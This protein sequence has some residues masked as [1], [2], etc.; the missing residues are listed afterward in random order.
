MFISLYTVRVILN[1]L[2]IVDYG[3]Y[4]V[5]AGIVTMF[6]FLSGAMATASQRFFSFEMGRGDHDKLQKTFCM[7]MSIYMLIALVVLVLAESVGLWFVIA[8]LVIPKNRMHAAL[9]VYQFSIMSFL[10]T[11]ITTPYIAVIIARENMDVYA[12][13]SILESL[14]KLAVVFFLRISRFDSLV[15][16]GILIFFV[17]LIVS[18]LFI[19]TCRK[20]YPESRFYFY[21]DT[22]M[23]K[24]LFS[25]TGW[26]LFGASSGIAKN[27]AINIL[28]NL[29]FGP[30]VNAARGIAT[31]VSGAVAS[32]SQNFSIAV[33]P[34]IIKK[35]AAGEKEEM[36]KLVFLS[37]KLTSFLMY[38]FVLPLYLEMPM[39]MLLWLGQIPAHVVAFTRLIL[40][41][42]LI[43]SI[44]Y[45][46]MTASQATGKI[47]LYQ[48]TIGSINLLNLPVSWIALQLG[49]VPEIVFVIMVIITVI[50]FIVRLLI[51]K[52]LCVFSIKNYWKS[53][54][55]PVSLVSIFGAIGPIF[56]SSRFSFGIAR[57]FATLIVSTLTISV[58]ILFLGLNRNERHGLLAK[59]HFIIRRDH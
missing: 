40:I 13:V 41:D 43:D 19:F 52:R 10:A 38:V 33:R 18:S 42:T 28:L 21:W 51:I 12:Y 1:I 49:A 57:M 50:A 59:M 31:Q 17:T 15:L 3:V 16:Y 6:G 14:L 23:F 37:S 54:I 32:F 36:M 44:S 20:R 29:Y 7:S 48:A 56:I 27:Q 45:P 26:N 2:G 22:S 30:S 24:T 53:V 47:K 35:Y 9:W 4:N 46:L 11:L 8:K 39:V 58:F 34:Q 5:V 25:Y 55:V